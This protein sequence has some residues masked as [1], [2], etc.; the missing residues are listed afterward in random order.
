M[1]VCVCVCVCVRASQAVGQGERA[2]KHLDVVLRAIGGLV[3]GM[4]ALMATPEQTQHLLNLF[5]IAKAQSDNYTQ[6]HH[7]RLFGLESDCK[8][9]DVSLVCTAHPLHAPQQARV[10]TLH[11]QPH[12]LIA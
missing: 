9:A 1:C 5:P 12:L 6:G 4:P 3:P 7:Y 11:S 10:R 8:D 2:V